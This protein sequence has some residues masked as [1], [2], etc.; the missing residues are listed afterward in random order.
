MPQIFTELVSRGA[1]PDRMYNTFNMGI[2]F[3][4]AVNASKALDIM[5]ELKD[6]GQESYVI[7]RV[8]KVSKKVKEQTDAVIFQD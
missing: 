6:S 1:N 4:M 2:G 5:S 8:E 3:V 7:G